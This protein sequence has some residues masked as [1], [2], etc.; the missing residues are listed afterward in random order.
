[1]RNFNLI[2]AVDNNWGIGK[3]GNLLVSNKKDME[4]FK[5]TTTGHA[6][7]MGRKTYDSIGRLLPNRF[8]LVVTTKSYCFNHYDSAVCN[9]L[10]ADYIEKCIDF[11]AD[12]RFL[13]KAIFVIGG[14]QIYT[15]FL[16]KCLNKIKSIYLT[17]YENNLNA[18]T[19]VP[20]IDALLTNTTNNNPLYSKNTLLLERRLIDSGT[21]AVGGKFNIYEYKLF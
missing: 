6:V 1:M 21:D 15:Y 5:K 20:N 8:N 19:F 9:E 2:L 18:D 3:E 12:D 7:V 16:E 13:H 10:D 14:A 11:F 17:K 4:F